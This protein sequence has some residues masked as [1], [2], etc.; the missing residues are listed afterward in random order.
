MLDLMTLRSRRLLPAAALAVV[1]VLTG[2]GGNDGANGDG[3]GAAA[4]KD[5]RDSAATAGGPLTKD[6]FAQ[7]LAGAQ[8]EAGS[9]HFTM[10]AGEGDQSVTSKGKFSFDDSGTPASQMATEMGDV[11]SMDLVMTGGKLYLNMGALTE[12]KYVEVDLDEA[13]GEYGDLADQSDP[14]HQLELMQ[15]SVTSFTEEGDGPTI[16]GVA[17]TRYVV[18]LDTEKVLEGE[19]AAQIE[20]TMPKTLTYELFVG[21]DDLVRR[22]TYDLAGS[23]F[24]IDYTKWGEDVSIAAPGKDQIT[25]RD[26]FAL[27]GS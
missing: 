6:N 2:C 15:K 18:A 17:T 21:A 19:D 9:G 27:P 14:T 11:Y 20:G 22:I 8:V 10:T 25:D 23:T 1:L 7:R 16:D 3:A 26:P 5:D 13:A 24:I 4:G 12:N